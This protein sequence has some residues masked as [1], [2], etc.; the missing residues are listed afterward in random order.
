VSLS[1]EVSLSPSPDP[2]QPTRVAS[3]VGLAISLGLCFGAAGLGGLF[4]ASSVGSWFQT[5]SKPSWNPPDAVFGPVWSALFVMMA[6][7][8]WLVWR[9]VGARAGRTSL[10]LFGLQLV[11]NVGWSA[12][13]FGLRRPDL[14]LL[15]IALLWLAIAA[16]AW[17]FRRHSGWAALLLLPYLAWVSFATGLNAAIWRLNG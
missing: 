16:T 9:R 13:F 5:L 15:E 6:V 12:L 2:Q 3:L 8:A 7:A 11:L 4:T 14:A 1:L 10:M 17:S